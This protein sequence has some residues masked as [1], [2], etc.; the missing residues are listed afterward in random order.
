MELISEINFG[1]NST[2][3]KYSSLIKK[4]YQR[5]ISEG[6]FNFEDQIVSAILTGDTK[7]FKKSFRMGNNIG[8]RFKIEFYSTKFNPGQASDGE[9]DNLSG[10]EG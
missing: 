3:I 2:P 5:V 7:E 8:V 9:N 4:N 6:S 1:L 10:T